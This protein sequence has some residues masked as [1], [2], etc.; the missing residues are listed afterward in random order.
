MLFR[1]EQEKNKDI[2]VKLER[3]NLRHGMTT[4]E[5]FRKD[6]RLQLE[7]IIGANRRVEEQAGY[8]VG[9]GGP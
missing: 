5:Q 2:I 1:S 7:R 3:E 9:G 4:N 8:F 6:L